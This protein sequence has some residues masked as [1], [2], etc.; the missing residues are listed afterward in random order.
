MPSTEKSQGYE[1]S[2][3]LLIDLE[4]DKWLAAVLHS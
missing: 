3:L 4:V 1:R 2:K